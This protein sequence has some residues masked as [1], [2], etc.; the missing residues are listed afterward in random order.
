MS[1]SLIPI[2]N[3]NI[4]FSMKNSVVFLIM[5]LVCYNK[6]YTQPLNEISVDAHVDKANDYKNRKYIYSELA[7]LEEAYQQN[8][9]KKLLPRMAELAY[10]LRDYQRSEKYFKSIVDVDKANGNHTAAFYYANLL[11]LQ[12][13]YDMASP[14]FQRLAQ[15]GSEPW[16][17][18]A[19]LELEGISLANNSGKKAKYT[20]QSLGKNINSKNAEYSPVIFENQLYYASA[21]AGE[22]ELKGNNYRVK[23]YSSAIGTDATFK[24]SNPLPAKINNAGDVLS[25]ISFSLDGKIMYITK[26]TLAGD[27]LK[28]SQLLYSVKNG[29]EWSEPKPTKGLFNSAIILHPCE[30][31]LYGKNVLFFVSNAP[32]GKGGYDI[33]YANIKSPGVFEHPINL[34]DQ[35]NTKA[36]EITPFYADG[37]LVFASKGH[38]GFGG[39]D[40]FQ[41]AWNGTSWG[42]PQ[43]MGLGINSSADDRFY[44]MEKDGLNGV[45]TSNREG[46]MSF[47]AKS[48][49]DDIFGFTLPMPQIK[50]NI[51]VF[52]GNKPL[53]E[54]VIGLVS[55]TRTNANRTVTLDQ[56]N[57]T[58]FD[59]E[60]KSDY[61]IKVERPGYFPDSITVS[62]HGIRKDSA[63]NI[64]FRLKPKPEVEVI[65]SNQPIRLNNIYYDY[66]SDKI[67]KESETELDFLYDILK[68]YPDMVIEL[69]S[70]TDSRG[71]DEYNLDLSQ[72]RAQSATNYL[73]NKGVDAERIVPKGYGETMLLNKCINGVK[74]T[75]E[76]HKYNRRTE[77]KIIAGP[78]TIEIKKR[79]VKE[80]GQVIKTETID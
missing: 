72:R 42:T 80:R 41:S 71:S 28:E 18:Y 16:K 19:A 38:P 74:C 2:I 58:V 44:F 30:G 15:N 50:F 51:E 39:Y 55:T 22:N 60:I 46:T 52:D 49:C 29:N 8:K 32:G 33:Y 17:S 73:L 53:Y 68:T 77:F 79:V 13:K 11:K 37:K 63:L 54:S 20:L 57:T 56:T 25:N 23:L 40:L 70:H 12:G 4:Y 43:N 10:K 21:N 7:Q 36:D 35:I 1:G 5:L 78:K 69:S 14:I 67:L 64:Q 34:G 26:A 61:M 47:E 45:L 75:D 31:E 59:G 62:T 9:D 65:T 3:Q 24:N 76:E 48:C 66:D 27:M 6:S